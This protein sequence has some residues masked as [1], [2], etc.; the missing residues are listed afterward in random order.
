M[1]IFLSLASLLLISVPAQ[2]GAIFSFSFQNVHG[3][4]QGTVSG[5]ITLSGTGDGTFAA[6]SIIVDAAPAT[7]GYTYP[8]DVLS[9]M[10]LVASNSFVV[11]N[12]QI[13]KGASEFASEGDL[14]NAFTLNFGSLGSLFTD[15]T[16]MFF[17]QDL[18]NTTLSYNS[19]PSL[20]AVPEPSTSFALVAVCGVIYGLRRLRRSA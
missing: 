10:P 9:N 14:N 3:I 1:R 12:G 4:V 19:S 7:L 6:T 18:S 16:G 2:A 17:V 11:S 15:S 8:F 20:A 5:T 13:D